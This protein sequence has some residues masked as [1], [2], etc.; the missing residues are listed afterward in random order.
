MNDPCML[1]HRANS[2]GTPTH[3]EPCHFFEVRNEN[4]PQNITSPAT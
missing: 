2:T 4:N 1:A 3:S